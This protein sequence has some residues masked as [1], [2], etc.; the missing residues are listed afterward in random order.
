MRGNNIMKK[1]IKNVK[2]TINNE[3]LE[4]FHEQCDFNKFYITYLWKHIKK[5]NIPVSY[6]RLKYYAYEIASFA[7][8]GS[9]ETYEKYY[10]Y[11]IEDVLDFLSLVDNILLYLVDD[12]EHYVE[13]LGKKFITY[14][15]KFVNIIWES[16]SERY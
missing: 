3:T 10:P 8:G 2:N 15:R 14:D 7:Y 13:F 4:N 12:E 6:E 16:A 11:E 1:I 9:L 5:G